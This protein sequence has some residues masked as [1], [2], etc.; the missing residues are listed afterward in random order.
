[1]VNVEKM[2][3]NI[4]THHTLTLFKKFGLQ[5]PQSYI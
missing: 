1:M 2:E 5:N 3:I 4:L